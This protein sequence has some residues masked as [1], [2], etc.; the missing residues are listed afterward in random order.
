MWEQALRRLGAVCVTLNPIHSHKHSDREAG[1]GGTARFI[2][3]QYDTCGGAVD[4]DM[5]VRSFR[6]ERWGGDTAL[7]FMRKS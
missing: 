6:G 7:V 4:S 3:H 2:T 5:A 1:V